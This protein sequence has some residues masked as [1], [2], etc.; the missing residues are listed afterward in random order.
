LG[1]ILGL[2]EVAHFGLATL[3]FL[4]FGIGALSGSL[5]IGQG[6][7]ANAAN[8]IGACAVIALLPGVIFLYFGL[9]LA[10]E[11][12][13][14]QD[15]SRFLME[16]QR[17]SLDEVA[18]RFRWSPPDAEDKIV[19]AINE[20]HLRGNFDR[21]TKQFFTEGSQQNMEFIAR[22][23]ICGAGIGMWAS[24]MAPAKCQYCGAEPRPGFKPP[25]PPPAP[26]PVLILAP[27]GMPVT[28]A[29]YQ[30]GMAPAA[31]QYGMPSYGVPAYGVPP[32]S[33][34][35][36]GAP[37]Y[38]APPYYPPAVAAVPPPPAAGP[39]QPTGQGSDISP[40][41]QEVSPPPPQ[42]P[43]KKRTVKFLFFSMKSGALK[44]I[45]FILF[46]IGVMFL[47][48]AIGASFTFWGGQFFMIVC[49]GVLYL[50]PLLIGAAVIVRAYREEKYKEQLLDIVDYIE[51]YRRI[52][53]VMLA[54]KMSLPEDRVRKI[55]SD[56]LEFELVEG[57]ITQDNSEFIV[58]LR[59][60][61]VKTVRSC[62]Y[63]K[64]PSLNLQIIR[65]GSE[66]CPYCSGVIYFQEGS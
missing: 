26:V 1:K 23:G 19:L 63:C 36:Y 38:G 59:K 15:M 32:Y 61:D 54:R 24:K 44:T 57:Y 34:P 31:Q 49:S 28:G 41:P 35:P 65:G 53:F 5:Y 58:A 40:Y 27:P 25:A 66:K 52:T 8:V 7:M 56:I 62:P 10:R 16:K 14:L 20:G 55:V 18:A 51:T 17:T 12:S 11:R 3:F 30:Y 42:P 43:K 60:E 2:G 13:V 29:P 22:C 64:N 46:S 39:V 9:K 33:A 50:P 45:G 6:D 47:L 4:L 48:A 37:P 21:G